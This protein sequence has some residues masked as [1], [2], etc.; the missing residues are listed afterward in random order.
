MCC[1][2][3]SLAVGVVAM[4]RR[5]NLE[6][7]SVG[8]TLVKETAASFV[9][10]ALA[11]MSSANITTPTSQESSTITSQDRSAALIVGNGIMRQRWSSSNVTRKLWPISVGIVWRLC[12][13]WPTL[14]LTDAIVMA[15]SVRR[16]QARSI[17]NPGLF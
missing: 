8:V 12:P 10:S 9:E 11:P 3:A 5:T 4:Q 1:G 17:A 15:L 7:A 16:C 2:S 13:V 14:V 6:I